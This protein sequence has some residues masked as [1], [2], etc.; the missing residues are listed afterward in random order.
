MKLKIIVVD[1]ELS[2]RQKLFG[3]LGLATSLALMSTVALANHVPYEEGE[4]L[5]ATK[6][7]HDFQALSTPQSGFLAYN[8]TASV[9]NNTGPVIVFDDEVFDSADEYD[10]TTGEFTTAE[11]G[12]YDVGCNL[13]FDSGQIATNFYMETGIFVNGAR[14]DVSASRGDG[15]VQTFGVRSLLV[16][17][18]GDVLTC[19]GYSNASTPISLREV[20]PGETVSSFSALRRYAL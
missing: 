13:I 15:Y 6:L 8:T 19:D 2:R 10:A 14:T 4:V 1:L 9:T 16:L 5:S 3:G 12:Y 11:G 20:L 7:N 18:P 17:Q